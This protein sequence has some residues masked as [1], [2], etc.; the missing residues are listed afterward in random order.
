MWPPRTKIARPRLICSS[1]GSKSKMI[2]EQVCASSGSSSKREGHAVCSPFLWL[3]CGECVSCLHWMDVHREAR[4][5]W[6][7][8]SASPT[9]W[10]RH[11]GSVTG[12]PW[13]L[14]L[15]PLRG[16]ITSVWFKLFKVGVSVIA[17][18]LLQEAFLALLKLSQSPQS[19]V[20]LC[21][22]CFLVHFLLPARLLVGHGPWI[23]PAHS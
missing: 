12:Q 10:S 14:A 20:R 23:R 21:F 22:P 8:A 6:G 16:E 5:Q 13:M 15:R 7:R 3:W 1:A 9:A 4:T 2:Y 19:L 17:A 11:P 18:E